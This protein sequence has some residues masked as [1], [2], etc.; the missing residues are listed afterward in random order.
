MLNIVRTRTTLY[1][2]GANG[3]VERMELHHFADTQML[4]SRVAGGLGSTPRYCRYGN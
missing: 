2:P 1:R 3:Q 4:Y